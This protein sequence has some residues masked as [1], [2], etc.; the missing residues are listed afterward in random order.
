MR[1][2][3]VE[4][5]VLAAIAVEDAGDHER[6]PLEVG[7][8][9]D[10]AASIEGDRPGAVLWMAATLEEAA[11]EGDGTWSEFCARGSRPRAAESPSTPYPYIA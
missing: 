10:P 2:L 7:L 1:R 6:Q 11:N 5:Y 4:P 3:L 9:A 8:P